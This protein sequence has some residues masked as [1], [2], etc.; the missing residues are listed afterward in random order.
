MP[1][2]PTF[3]STRPTPRPPSRAGTMSISQPPMA[4]R[5]SGAPS[6]M[7][8][9]LNAARRI[10]RARH[11]PRFTRPMRRRS[12][13]A[14]QASVRAN[15]RR[16]AARRAGRRMSPSVSSFG[17]E[18]AVLLHLIASIDPSVPVLFLETGKHFPETLAYRDLNWSQRLGLTNLINLTPDP[19]AAGRARRKRAALVLRSRWLLRNPQGRCR[20]PP[21]WPGSM[22]ASPAARAF[23]ARPAPACPVRDRRPTRRPA[24]DQSAGRLVKR[25]DRAY[26]A[27]TGLPRT[28]WWRKAIP[29][30]AA[31][32]A[33]ARSH[34]AK[35]ARARPLEGL[36]QDRMRH[37]VLCGRALHIVGILG[38]VMPARGLGM[39]MTLAAI[40]VPAGY[41]ASIAVR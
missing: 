3:R 18:S 11:L 20:W 32:P 6:G 37:P 8:Q 38:T 24:Q 12:T 1:S 4:A 21:R 23:K 16:S 39:L 17:A 30:S 19:E 5:R 26:F 22:L 13:R 14:F 28:R 10:D 34:R 36:G 7:R 2:P 9:W 15:A 29:R 33:P 31:R 41:L 27:A 40:L 25:P 35:T